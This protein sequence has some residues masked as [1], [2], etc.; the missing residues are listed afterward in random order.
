MLIPVNID[1]KK[2]LYMH[3]LQIMAREMFL[4]IVKKH[5]NGKWAF[6]ELEWLVYVEEI[7]EYEKLSE[8]EKWIL[9]SFMRAFRSLYK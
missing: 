3:P 4:D 1:E 8:E 5:G 9:N 2:N 6:E 7:D